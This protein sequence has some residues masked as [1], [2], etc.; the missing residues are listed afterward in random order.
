VLRIRSV[1]RVAI[2]GRAVRLN[3]AEVVRFWSRVDQ[4]A[5]PDGCWPWIGYL[6]SRYGVFYFG[7]CRQERAHRVAERIARGPLGPDDRVLHR[8]D[9]PP[10]CNPGHLFRGTQA[11]NV[12]DMIAKGRQRSVSRYGEANPMATLSDA[13]VE[14][15]RRMR[16][17]GVLLADLSDEF[18]VAR[19]TVS[20]ICN[21]KLRARTAV[22]GAGMETS[23]G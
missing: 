19:S 15:M 10:C 5:G 23:D 7:R 12:A 11:D 13:E 3:E 16:R 18:H 14:R 2:A 22:P 1:F 4:S 9:N 6:G 8:C 17:R 20:R 21:Y